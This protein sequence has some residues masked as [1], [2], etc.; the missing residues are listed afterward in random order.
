[1]QEVGAV[2]GYDPL[3]NGI[4]EVHLRTAGKADG[5]FSIDGNV[6]VQQGAFHAPWL[7]LQHVALQTNVHLDNTTMLFTQVKSVLD[8]QGHVDGML[9]LTNW[10]DSPPPVPEKKHPA[11]RNWFGRRKKP[12]LVAIKP[13]PQ[14]LQA[15][16]EATV[17][18]LPSPLVLAAVAPYRFDDLGFT[19]DV[20]GPVHGT[21]HGP[22][23]ALDI[24]GDLT[25]RPERRARPGSLPVNGYVKA[26]Y[27]G[28]NEHLVF[29]QADLTTPGTEVHATGTMSL[30]PEDLHSA[31]RGTVTIQHLRE[32]DRLLYI[33][34]DTTPTSRAADVDRKPSGKGLVHLPVHLLGPASFRG[35][36]T[37]SLLE[38]QLDGHVDAPGFLTDLG[39]FGAAHPASNV[40]QTRHALQW[41]SLH[42][43][44]SYAPSRIQVHHAVLTRGATTLHVDAQLRP[45]PLGKGNYAYSAKS[46]LVATARV[47]DASVTDVQ[48]IA[49]TRFPT[50]GTL[51]A[52]AQVNGVIENLSGSGN[53]RV[54]DLNIAG[55][56]VSLAVSRLTASGHL[57]QADQI[58][59]RTADG[60]AQGE[61]SYDYLSHAIQ[62]SITG[63]QFNLSR[64]HPLQTAR[65]SVGGTGSFHLLAAGT[66][67]APV[68]TGSVVIDNV[69][70]NGE[71]MGQVH[72]EAN[73]RG[74][75]VFLTSRAQ[76]LQAQ[77]KA[78]GQVQLASGFPAAL[79]LQFTDFDIQPVLQLFTH[80]GI[81]GKSSIRGEM[82]LQGPLGRPREIVASA[83]L[84][85][86]S[87][88][89]NNIPLETDG[90]VKFSVREGLLEL[91]PV[92]IKGKDTD[93]KIQGTANLL[94]NQRLRV[95]AEGGIN[96]GLAQTFSSDLIA[97]GH[98]D[99]VVDA[100]GTL[101]QPRLTG[102]MQVTNLA[103][104]EQNVTNGLSQMN[105]TLAF[106]QDRL[107]IQQ[108]SGYTGGG[109]VEFTGFATFRN[110]L[111]FDVAANAKDARIRYPQGVTSMADANLHLDGSLDALLLRGNVLLTR[112]A[113]SRNVDLGALAAAANQSVATPPDPT[114][115]LNS[116]RLDVR[117]TS[118]PQLG[119]QNSFATLAGDVNLH[120]R[121]TMANPSILGRVDITQGKA[122]FAGTQYVLQRGDIVFTNPVTIQPEVNLEA[123]A[124]VRNYD[125]IIGLNG[126]ANKLQ[127]NY[128]SEP[129]LSQADV[130]ALLT[131]GRTNEE[132]TMYGE[133]Q[134]VGGDPTTEALLGGALNAAVSSRVQ[135]LFGV[136]S[137]RVDPN[138]VGVLG[139]STARVTVEQ[140][141]GRN[142]TLVFATSVNT[143][144]Q[145]LLQAQY[146]ISRNLSIIA[147]RDEADVFSL[148]FQIRGKRR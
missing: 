55:Q 69:T 131:L 48:A 36:F 10:L 11:K 70:L 74:K 63:Q 122:T 102:R 144:A 66:S 86:F 111:F 123:T 16:L 26:D 128:R 23:H 43:D 130:L 127:V 78:G 105:G 118:S 6:A 47:T 98:V 50:T 141:V 34:A 49:G 5:E 87:A 1:L 32:F 81:T 62:G 58:R 132:A 44:V 110:G 97:S 39:G 100:R 20:T 89:I 9:R 8:G 113:V 85:R 83:D 38:P 77:L 65:A 68:A 2:T 17:T 46:G 109:K 88:T 129:P 18:D 146:A 140:Q 95:H 28:D 41:D 104:Q 42:A 134:Q 56:S 72:A 116:V 107:V 59:I 82:Q 30:L 14:P 108:L 79:V 115:P 73:L 7:Q 37:G 124:R 145:Q 71:P 13:Q 90:P 103:V 92:H 125:I 22:G 64:I 135:Q 67:M 133:Q 45:V 3:R 120:I 99:F 57:L 31:M 139:Q 12:A 60:M 121:G 51:S 76:L 119:F 52:N 53:L 94:G 33:L 29:Q 19:A 91:L 112:F 126:P 80:A 137:V 84:D 101:H 40:S 136:A 61:L 96:A 27:L 148:Y 114:S 142:L 54:T 75:T 25:F 138:F 35:N 117:I 143:T 21:W 24:H 93:L 106:D 15:L 4:A 147:V